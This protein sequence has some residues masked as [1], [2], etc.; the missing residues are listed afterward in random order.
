MQRSQL[1]RRRPALAAGAVQLPGQVVLPVTGN[2]GVASI[3]A[4]KLSNAGGTFSIGGA[5]GIPGEPPCPARPGTACVGQTGLGGPMGLVGTLDLHVI[6]DIVVIPLVLSHIAVGVGGAGVTS[7]FTVAW[8]SPA[9]LLGLALGVVALWGRR[10]RSPANASGVGC[11]HRTQGGRDTGRRSAASSPGRAIPTIRRSAAVAQSQSTMPDDEPAGSGAESGERKV[12]KLPAP[13]RRRSGG[14]LGYLKDHPGWAV[15]FLV[16]TVL[17]AVGIF[18]VPF[19]P[20]SLSTVQKVL[21]GALVGFYFSL[22]PIV[23]RL[24]D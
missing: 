24:F 12:V 21:G 19:V 11:N 16:C 8:P 13:P 22:F 14:P 20:E 7:P 15:Y 23:H 18:Y 17:G 10:E 1:D 3:T 4:T 5:A 2:T 9:L 6:P